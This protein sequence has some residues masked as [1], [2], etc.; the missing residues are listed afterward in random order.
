MSNQSKA[1]ETVAWAKQRLDEIDAVVSQV[2]KTADKLTDDTR[3]QAEAALVRLQA[4]RAKV[5]TYYDQLRSEADSVKSGFEHAREALEAEWVEVE[6]AFQDF[7]A[8]AKDQGESVHEAVVARVAAQ[9]KSWEASF[10]DLRKQAESVVDKARA[11]FDVAIKQLS[12][13]AEKF[14]ARIGDAKDAGDESWTAV[15]NG[16]ADAKTV[17]DRTIE[18]IK[19]AFSKLF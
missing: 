2:E 17:H 13:E 11:D 14:Q 19:D 10:A 9:R 3:A 18:R 7:L 15:K 1:H 8:A 16:L 12:D 5:Q 4:S 6:T